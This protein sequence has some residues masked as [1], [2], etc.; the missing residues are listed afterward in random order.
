MI[1]G[2]LRTGSVLG[3]HF[4]GHFSVVW[5]QVDLEKKM[6]WRTWGIMWFGGLTYICTRA[7]GLVSL[8]YYIFYGYRY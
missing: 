6:V 2:G 7:R 4:G 3:D 1:S 5:D 8:G